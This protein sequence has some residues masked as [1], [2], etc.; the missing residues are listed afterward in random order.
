MSTQLQQDHYKIKSKLYEAAKG[1]ASELES[2]KVSPVGGDLE[3]AF[4]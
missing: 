4:F 1:S 2:S 3:G